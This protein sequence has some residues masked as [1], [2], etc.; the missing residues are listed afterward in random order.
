MSKEPLKQL[1]TFVRRVYRGGKM[2]G[3]F[4][5][6]N[7]AADGFTPE[8]WISSFTAAKNK[9]IVENEGITRVLYGGRQ[10]LITEAVSSADFGEGRTQSG[11]LIKFLDAAER[12]GIQ[13]HPTK[14]YAR[15]YFSSDYGKTECWHILNTR[16]DGEPA[17]VY[18]GFRENV[19]KELWRD[20]FSRQD[21]DGMLGAMH[22]F[23]VQPGDTVLVTGGTPHAIGEGCFLL[24]IQEPSD[25]TMRAEITTAAMERLTP[26][27]IHYGVGVDSMLDCFNYTPR[28]CEEVK[29]MFFLKPRADSQNPDITHLVTYSDTPCFKLDKIETECISLIN[30]CFTTVISLKNG[31]TLGFGDTEYPLSRGD[32]FFIP[33]NTEIVLSNSEA[34]VCYPPEES[35]GE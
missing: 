18:L 13:V 35:K 6:Q 22:H 10:T 29:E 12:L 16:K 15:R 8:D 9:D 7:G 32:K 5:G 28:T 20:L 4:L 34:L 25:Y 1:P 14:E 33:A 27:Q 23:E 2:L 11:L 19:T 17:V 31:G 26:M 3:E 21:I 24:E 30:E